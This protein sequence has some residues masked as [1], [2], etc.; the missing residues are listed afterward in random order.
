[1][2]AKIVTKRTGVLGLSVERAYC[3]RCG[4]ALKLEDFTLLS[5][6]PQYPHLCPKC[7]ARFYLNAVYPKTAFTLDDVTFE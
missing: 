2:E 7:D 1:M 5:N 6:P 3:S 4:V